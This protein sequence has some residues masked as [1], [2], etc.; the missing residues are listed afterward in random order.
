MPYDHKRRRKS[1]AEGPKGKGTKRPASESDQKAKHEKKKKDASLEG[2]TKHEV[3]NCS[4][5]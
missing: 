4:S 1:S 5:V 2:L 3:Q